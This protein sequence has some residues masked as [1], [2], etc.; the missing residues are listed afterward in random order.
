[1]TLMTMWGGRISKFAD[2]TK[3]GQVVNS[4]DG[5]SW[6]TRRYRRNGQMGR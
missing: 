5:V 1:M 4:E 3:I 2:D 6:A